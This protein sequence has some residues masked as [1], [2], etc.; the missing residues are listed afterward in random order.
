MTENAVIY[1]N[2]RKGKARIGRPI[3]QI[4]EIL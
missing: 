2:P 3:E 4:L 1:H